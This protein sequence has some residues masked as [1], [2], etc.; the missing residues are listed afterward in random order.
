[1]TSSRLHHD[2]D[3]KRYAES[4]LTMLDKLSILVSFPRVIESFLIIKLALP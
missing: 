1:M 2:Y 4:S 3:I